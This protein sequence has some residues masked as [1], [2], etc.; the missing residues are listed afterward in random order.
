MEEINTEGK[1]LE[2]ESIV[3][4]NEKVTTNAVGRGEKEEEARKNNN[5]NLDRKREEELIRRK[6]EIERNKQEIRRAKEEMERVYQIL[7]KYGLDLFSVLAGL[8]IFTALGDLAKKTRGAFLDYAASK[9][10]VEAY[11]IEE[12]LRN[13]END[14]KQQ[15]GKG[16]Q[17]ERGETVNANSEE[18]NRVLSVADRIYKAINV[19]E[20]F[21]D[22][23]T[24]PAG[25]KFYERLNKPVI[26]GDEPQAEQPGLRRGPKI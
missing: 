6:N 19:D 15:V 5:E 25:G 2:R 23:W 22:K 14:V 7:E 26:D 13:I 9:L 16:Q 8:H 20:Y 21:K 1:E 18:K 24:K 10:G 3:S 4:E 11:E 17:V 12:K